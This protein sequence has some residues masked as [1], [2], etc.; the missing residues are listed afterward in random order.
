MDPLRVIKRC[1]AVG[2]EDVDAR[3]IV[4]RS[5]NIRYEIEPFQQG[6]N[7]VFRRWIGLFWKDRGWHSQTYWVVRLKKVGLVDISD[8]RTSCKLPSAIPASSAYL[9]NIGFHHSQPVPFDSP[10]PALNRIIDEFSTCPDPVQLEVE[11]RLRILNDVVMKDGSLR[12]VALPLR[13]QIDGKVLR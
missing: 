5:H 3:R 2:V 10:T 7:A 12:L 9:V 8:L 6:R 1:G 11:S 4:S 13:I